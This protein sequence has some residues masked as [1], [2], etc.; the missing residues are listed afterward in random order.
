M[1]FQVEDRFLYFFLVS[2]SSESTDIFKRTIF[3]IWSDQQPRSWRGLVALP[4]EEVQ[5]GEASKQALS[6]IN[7][8]WYS[9][10]Q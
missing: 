10:V 2:H 8:L 7:I 1:K 4:L 5:R 6:I 9:V 3:C